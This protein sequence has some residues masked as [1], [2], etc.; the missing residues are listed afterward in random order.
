M[1]VDSHR[2]KTAEQ[3]NAIR[4]V[5]SATKL[6]LTA[7]ISYLQTAQSPT[8]EG[9][10]DIL[11]KVLEENGCESPEGHIVCG[12]R[13]SADP[14]APGSGVLKK[15][16]PIVIDIYPRSKTTGYFSDMSRT[17]CIGPAPKELQE[18][19]KAVREAQELGIKMIKPGAKCLDIQQAIE[20]LFIKKGYTTSGKGTEFPFAEGFV[21][22]VGHG[23][24]LKV[25][26]A[27]KVGR[28][29]KDILMVGDVVTVEPG[30]YYKHI[31]G[32]RL[33]DI[34]VVTE[35]GSEDLTQFPKQ[36][37]I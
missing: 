11:D 29:S 33:E 35:E 27:P 6:S 1:L 26:E 17:V 5:Q 34:L 18:M 23:V 8:S 31:G 2:K 30:L 24:G 20:A 21:H 9:A 7:V 12:G 37:E 13:A 28:K 36:L 15:S 19:Y 10:H 16:E 32:V 14:H 25:H 3:I 4:D 22:S